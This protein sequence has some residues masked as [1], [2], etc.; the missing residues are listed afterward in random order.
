MT[1]HGNHNQ[2][3][4]NTTGSIMAAL[5]TPEIKAF[6]ITKAGQRALEQL[7]RNRRICTIGKYPAY[8][9]FNDKAG[10]SR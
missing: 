2:Y 6:Y 10:Q 5:I 9:R 7:K 3:H 1:Q 4:V 8:L